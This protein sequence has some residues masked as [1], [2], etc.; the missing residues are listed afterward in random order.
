MHLGSLWK[1]LGNID[2]DPKAQFGNQLQRNQWF[3]RGPT[4][5]LGSIVSGDEEPKV[6]FGRQLQ[7]N[8]LCSLAEGVSGSSP[9][10][11]FAELVLRLTSGAFGST[12]VSI[13]SIWEH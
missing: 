6:Y 12:F 7:R 13:G 2:V 3:T 9:N 8:Q 5:F 4:E 10:V 11:I 1:H